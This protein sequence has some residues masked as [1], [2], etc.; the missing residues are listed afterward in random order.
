[1]LF[2]D[3]AILAIHC[4]DSSV[5]QV[6]QGLTTGPNLYA[7]NVVETQHAELHAAFIFCPSV[8]FMCFISHFI[9]RFSEMLVNK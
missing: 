3:L 4:N 6:L 9:I 2:M 1:M 8:V 7:I 5:K